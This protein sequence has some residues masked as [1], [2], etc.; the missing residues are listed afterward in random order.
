MWRAYLEGT[1][2]VTQSRIN[3]FENYKNDITDPAKTLRLYKE[4][5]LKRVQSGEDRQRTEEKKE[6]HHLSVLTLI[7]RCCAL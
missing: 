6:K 3:V 4:Q 7:V 1:V 2:Q 5:Q